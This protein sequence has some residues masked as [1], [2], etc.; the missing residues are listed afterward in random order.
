M[1]NLDLENT[2]GWLAYVIKRGE[3]IELTVLLTLIAPGAP[4]KY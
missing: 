2:K 3:D 1:S 4:Q